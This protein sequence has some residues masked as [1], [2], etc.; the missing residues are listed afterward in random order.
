MEATNSLLPRPRTA[1]RYYPK[2]AGPKSIIKVEVTTIDEF[3]DS[4]GSDSIDVL[5]LDIQG[6]EL[7]AFQGAAKAL[8]E[9]HVRLIFTETMFVPH[10]EGNPLFYELWAF[11]A[12]FG[13]TLLDFYRLKKAANGQLRFGDALFINRELRD[14]VVDKSPAEP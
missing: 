13:Y 3:V 9:N 10:Y 7:M 6:G 4:E 12:D 11:L 8:R 14:V 5:K 1:R 2:S